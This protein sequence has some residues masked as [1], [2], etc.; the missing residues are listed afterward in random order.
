MKFNKSNENLILQ[1][2]T[3]IITKK[4]ALQTQSNIYLS[5]NIKTL[6]TINHMDMQIIHKFKRHGYRELCTNIYIGLMCHPRFDL[7]QSSMTNN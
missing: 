1:V 7:V 3:Y 6:R 2:Y 4:N 5:L